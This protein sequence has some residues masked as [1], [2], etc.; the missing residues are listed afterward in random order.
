MVQ[1]DWV[2]P[3]VFLKRLGGYLCIQSLKYFCLTY[4]VCTSMTQKYRHTPFTDKKFMFPRP[5][6]LLYFS[7]LLI[8]IRQNMYLT[9]KSSSF[10]ALVS[11]KPYLLFHL[12]HA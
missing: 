12:L 2:Q 3:F 9:C 5:G 8:K 10:S 7:C 6:M 11:L 4:C 1:S